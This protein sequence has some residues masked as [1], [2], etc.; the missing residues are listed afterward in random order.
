MKQVK[1]SRSFSKKIRKAGKAGLTRYSKQVHKV[2]QEEQKKTCTATLYHVQQ[3]YNMSRQIDQVE[4]ALVKIGF[5]RIGRYYS[6]LF[7]F[8]FLLFRWF[9]SC[10]NTCLRQFTSVND[11]IERT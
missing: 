8:V 1:R 6:S 7:F 2:K 11:D 9:L 5:N 3:V 10:G 4:H